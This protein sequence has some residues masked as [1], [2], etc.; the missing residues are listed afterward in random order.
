MSVG[1]AES[2]WILWIQLPEAGPNFHHSSESDHNHNSPDDSVPGIPA[3]DNYGS[4]YSETHNYDN[5]TYYY[6]NAPNYNH[7]KAYNDYYTTS[8][9]NEMSARTAE[10]RWIL[11]LQLS[12]TKLSQ[13]ESGW[14]LRVRL[15]KA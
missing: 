6:Y 1:T 5:P 15:S 7:D 3:T 12:Q 4:N 9:N 11:W 10:S 14:H 2:R 13:P 8:N